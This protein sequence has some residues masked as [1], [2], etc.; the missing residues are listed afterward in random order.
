MATYVMSDIHGE[1]DMFMEMLD[2]IHLQDRDNLF[3]V[4]DVIDRGPNPMKVV[5]KLMEMPNAFC[6][7]GNHEIMALDFFKF[8]MQEITEESIA[9][10]QNEDPEMLQNL[11]I[12]TERNGGQKTLDEF[13]KLDRDTQEEVIEFLKEF[14]LYEELT[15]CG[16]EYLLV[17]AGLGGYLP[18]KDIEEYSLDELVWSRAEYDIQYYP[19][20]YVITG[21]TPTQ[22]ISGNSKPGYIF[23]KNNHIAID[24]GC[25]IP[26][27][28]LAAFC[29]DN[30]KEYYVERKG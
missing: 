7:V 12:W 4:G 1:Y 2:K 27:G 18:G 29:L 20:K 6:I 10:L 26:G 25:Y 3:I 13:R 14:S 8:L 15:V 11:L 30:G 19:D 16:K 17:H 24:C 9:K 21:H 23:R 22:G 5:L 28:R